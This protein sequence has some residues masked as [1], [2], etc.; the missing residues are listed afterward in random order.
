M[1]RILLECWRH[2]WFERQRAE[3]LQYVAGLGYRV[4]EVAGWPEM[5]LLENAGE[6]SSKP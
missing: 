2:G 4:V 3:L 5:L 1:P 6:S